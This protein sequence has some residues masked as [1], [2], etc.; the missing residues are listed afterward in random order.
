MVGKKTLYQGRRACLPGSRND[1]HRT[2]LSPVQKKF[3][4]QS[5]DLYHAD[6]AMISNDLQGLE[7]N[8]K[9]KSRSQRG[10]S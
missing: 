10:F 5:G 9:I 4:L 8:S 1:D 7:N 3:F 2:G 6:D